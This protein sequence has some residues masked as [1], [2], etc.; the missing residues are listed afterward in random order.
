[1][2]NDSAIEFMENP[3]DLSHLIIALCTILASL[4]EITCRTKT[5]Y[6]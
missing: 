2:G 6:T 3:F 1:M 5:Q 4:K